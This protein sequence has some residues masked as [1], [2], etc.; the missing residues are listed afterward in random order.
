MSIYQKKDYTHINTHIYVYLRMH[1]PTYWLRYLSPHKCALVFSNEF[2]YPSIDLFAC[3]VFYQTLTFRHIRAALLSSAP[4]LVKVRNVIVASS[5]HTVIFPV[6]A[7][8]LVLDGTFFRHSFT[9][10]F[11]LFLLAI[12][13]F[14]EEGKHEGRDIIKKVWRDR[15]G[16]WR[17]QER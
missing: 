17:K 2:F 10:S 15:E 1:V 9:L 6:V 8:A 16:K 13:P 5:W 3:I 7:S 12:S 11:S 14:L 4:L